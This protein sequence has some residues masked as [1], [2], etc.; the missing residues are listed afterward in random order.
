MDLTL[1]D[2]TKDDFT[3]NRVEI[4]ITDVKYQDYWFNTNFK[5]DEILCG[6]YG[7]TGL[8]HIFEVVYGTPD[9]NVG[10]LRQ[11]RFSQDII[12]CEIPEVIN[13]LKELVDELKGD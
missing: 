8:E 12:L 7:E 9:N 6:E 3:F 5:S 1:K 10:I 4:K 11:F 2:L 13:I